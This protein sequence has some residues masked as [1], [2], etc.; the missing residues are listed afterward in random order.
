MHAHKYYHCV[1]SW[2]NTAKEDKIQ[3]LQGNLALNFFEKQFVCQ[4]IFSGSSH[5]NMMT[6]IYSWLIFNK[7]NFKII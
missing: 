3:Y 7:T 1:G 6:T 5:N 2:Y 4:Y